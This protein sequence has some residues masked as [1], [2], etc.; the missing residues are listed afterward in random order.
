VNDSCPQCLARDVKPDR[1][2]EAPRALIALYTCPGC[3]EQ[4]S[5]SW[6]LASL[7]H[8]LR[9]AARQVSPHTRIT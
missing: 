7:P 9:A 1:V 8:D 2:R 3:C 6:D 5:C 4:W